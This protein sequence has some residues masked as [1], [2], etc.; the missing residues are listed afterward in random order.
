MDKMHREPAAA[1][2]ATAAAAAKTQYEDPD[3]HGNAVASYN[4]LE[5]F[6]DRTPLDALINQVGTFPLRSEHTIIAASTGE[7]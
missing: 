7:Q 1:A 6:I 3:D 4:D 2:A 5:P